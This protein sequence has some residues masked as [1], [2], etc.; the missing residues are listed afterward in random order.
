MK[1]WLIRLLLPLLPTLFDIL[2][3]ALASLA[4]R[5]DNNID[6]QLVD[7]LRIN[8]EDVIDEVKSSL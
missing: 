5:T 2:L 7:T 6:D 8:K 4:R 3:D 1:V